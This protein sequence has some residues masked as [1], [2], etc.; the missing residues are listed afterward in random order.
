MLGLALTRASQRPLDLI[1]EWPMKEGLLSLISTQSNQIDSLSLAEYCRVPWMLE[2]DVH[3][4]N[5]LN[6]TTLRTLSFNIELE[7]IP[8]FMD[9]ALQSK[10]DQFYL[11]FKDNYP[12]EDI[13]KHA[14]M[15]RVSCIRIDSSQPTICFVDIDIDHCKG[16]HRGDQNLGGIPLFPHPT[17]LP[18]I[19]R[20]EIHG[21]L[22][23]VHGF[24]LSS[25]ESL[26]LGFG[27]YGTC[28]INVFLPRNLKELEISKVYFTEQ[29]IDGVGNYFL[30]NLTTLRLF[31]V[32]VEG[33]L[34]DY[35]EVPKLRV[36]HL[37]HILECELGD[38]NTEEPGVNNYLLFAQV[39]D[40]SFFSG[41]PDLESLKLRKIIMGQSVTKAFGLC[42]NL[43][44]LVLENCSIKD[45]ITTY[46]AD[47]ANKEYLPSL[48]LLKISGSWPLRCDIS[49]NDFMN[50]CRALRPGILAYGNADTFN[51]PDV[52]DGEDEED[53]GTVSSLES[54]S[55]FNS[56]SEARSD[57]YY[58]GNTDLS[59][60]PDSGSDSD[61]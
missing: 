32:A 21:E 43:K 30:P 2:V 29:L 48:H 27:Y 24:D 38:H 36:L 39:L 31:E 60:N 37:N 44:E 46:V 11:K 3:L 40:R 20:W 6:L 41:V 4:C 55:S 28:I 12:N 22:D 8:S 17:L 42:T 14:L 50:H 49:Y 59:S 18:N 15:K 47:M 56:G 7:N 35:F 33:T 25:A 57:A 51:D 1:V 13:L 16:V 9:L 19:K 61:S 58:T 5:G 34:D 45:L 10:Q 23:L 53:G 26:E 54:D 52:D